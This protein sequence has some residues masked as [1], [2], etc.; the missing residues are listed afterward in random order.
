LVQ[1]VLIIAACCSLLTACDSSSGGGGNV[2]EPPVAPAPIILPEI[3]SGPSIILDPLDFAPL[4]AEVTLTT[5]VPTSTILTISD[6][7]DSWT[8]EHSEFTD[9]HVL[10]V[11]GLKPNTSYTVEVNVVDGDGDIQTAMN[12]LTV[13][14]AP[15]PV[16][17]P[18]IEISVSD[19]ANME[20]G[21]T[22]LD[23]FR[24]NQ[25][26]DPSLR[27]Y[28]IILDNEGSVIWYSPNENV[29]FD[30]RQLGNGKFTY[31]S[32]IADIVQ[33]DLV[34]RISDSFRLIASCH[35]DRFVTEAGTFMCP[36]HRSVTVDGYPTS[37][38]DPNAPTQTVE[39]WDDLIAEFAADGS[40][41]KQWSLVQ[42]IDVGRV[43][44][45]T[46]LA[47]GPDGYDWAH[48][49]AVVHDP[50][51]DTIMVSSRFQ[52]AIVKFRRDG[53]LKW[54][55]SAH[56]N[57][58]SPYSDF[59][60]DPIG[61]NFDWPYGQ[62]AHEITPSGTIMIFDNGD[63]RADPFDGTTKVENADNYS[64]AVE[65]QIDE[66]NMEVSK[67]WEF[68]LM[69]PRQFS[70]H[71]GDADALPITGNVLI[72][73]PGIQ[74]SDGV[75]MSDLGKGFRATR[76]VEVTHDTPATV[77]FDALMYNPDPTGMI[78]VYRAERISSLYAPDV[79]EQR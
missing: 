14:T 51:D 79:I 55:L 35:H 28:A 45:R 76:L 3:T 11:L 26:E 67:V 2:P 4:A 33:Q 42:I 38:D 16:D 17:F 31:L 19:P 47:P 68:S 60:L 8:V 41:L 43:T 65:Y 12:P 52:N 57:W 18:I 74:H 37:H 77:V 73:F 64:R 25:G 21:Y 13:I 54:I 5:D 34:G 22:F 75:R 59:L 39:L 66:V 27:N 24:R 30:V 15:L 56:A 20:P 71:M 44:Y 49:N 53:S 50:G 69:A 40:F 23:Q 63:F 62:H 78:S 10:P 58:K 48:V 7:S 32:T 72:D 29:M 70:V 1:N 61:V 6:G 9:S 46:P 36:V